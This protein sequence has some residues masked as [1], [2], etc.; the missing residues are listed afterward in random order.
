MQTQMKE[1]DDY[2]LQRIVDDAQYDTIHSPSYLIPFRVK[3]DENNK[4]FF[5]YEIFNQ[6]IN[7]RNELKW[8]TFKNNLFYNR[9]D[10]AVVA[11]SFHNAKI[12]NEYD[13]PVII[14]QIHEKTKK[15]I[16]QSKPVSSKIN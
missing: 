14:T 5:W 16:T 9:T 13:I 1:L 7:S 10:G 8:E 15:L 4:V 6:T 2:R 3:E 12:H 11:V